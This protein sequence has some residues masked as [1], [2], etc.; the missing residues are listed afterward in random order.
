MHMAERL[1]TKLIEYADQ[2]DNR[3]ATDEM[4]LQCGLLMYIDF[5]QTHT[6]AD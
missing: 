5:E 1:V 4:F 3:G 6:R 2:I